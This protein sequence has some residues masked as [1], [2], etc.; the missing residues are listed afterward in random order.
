M[1]AS[2]GLPLQ[3]IG[4]ILDELAEKAEDPKDLMLSLGVALEGLDIRHHPDDPDSDEEDEGAR[5]S[6]ETVAV[7]TSSLSTGELSRV[8]RVEKADHRPALVRV[9]STPSTL[10]PYLAS[11]GQA[12]I[13]PLAR[14]SSSHQPPSTPFADLILSR[15]G[16]TLVTCVDR[17]PSTFPLARTIYLVLCGYLLAPTE[18]FSA[19]R[20]AKEQWPLL[21]RPFLPVEPR[22]EPPDEALAAWQQKVRIFPC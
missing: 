10:A 18:T 13:F 14:L 15:V 7:F 17:S 4:R 12:L 21:T 3:S 9:A 5:L 8:V 16:S 19:E 6:Y 2:S 22:H 11:Y 20:F 1:L